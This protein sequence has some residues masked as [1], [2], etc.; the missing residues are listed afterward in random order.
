MQGLKKINKI[1]S[2]SQKKTNIKTFLL[3]GLHLNARGPQSFL[4]RAAFHSQKLRARGS[5]LARGPQFA[6]PCYRQRF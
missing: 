1:K 3:C 4:S 5:Q 6:D 2:N